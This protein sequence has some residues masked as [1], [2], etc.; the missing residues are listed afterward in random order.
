MSKEK[1]YRLTVP[2]S[3]GFG[4]IDLCFYGFISTVVLLKWLKTLSENK[5]N[6][7]YGSLGNHNTKHYI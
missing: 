7:N 1:H 5:S 2:L 3:I 6:R 4:I